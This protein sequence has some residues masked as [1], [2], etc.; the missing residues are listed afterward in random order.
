MD[1]RHALHEA[2]CSTP[3]GSLPQSVAGCC[4]SPA[5]AATA[6]TG[7][8]GATADSALENRDR[9]FDNLQANATLSHSPFYSDAKLCSMRLRMPHRF[10]ERFLWEFGRRHPHAALSQVE[11][12]A[13]RFAKM[14]DS[15]CGKVDSASCFTQQRHAIHMEIRHAYAEVQHICGSLHS[16]GEDAFTQREVTLLSQKAP[17]ASFEKVSQLARHFL[18]LAQKCC[19][20][21][22]AA[23]CFLEERYA[24]HDELCHDDEVV[25]QVA[26]LAAC[27]A[28][29]GAAR[30]KCLEQLPRTEQTGQ[31]EMP[32]F[33][34]Q[35]IC[36]L[37]SENPEMLMEKIL[38]EF[39]RRHPDSAVSEVKHF[40]Q[41]FS[42]SVTECCASDKTH[43]CFVEKR[44]ALEK[45]IKD[46]EAKGQATCLQ[47]KTEGINHFEQLVMVNYAKAA[48][49]LT[50]ESVFEFAHRFARI[51]HQCCEHDT[52]C[53]LD[54]S[55]HLHAEM[56]GD[57]SYITAHPGAATC[58]KS[59]VSEQGACFK[60]HEDIHRAEDLLTAP[61]VPE[62]P[63]AE[64]VCLRY[65]QFPE[66][67]VN[68]ALYEFAHRLPLLDSSVLRSKALAYAD[69]TDD[70]CRAVDKTACFTEKV[71]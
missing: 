70:C 34:E 51:A 27:C 63:S 29:S 45:V 20:P 35:K 37:R 57:H 7:A 26:G 69:F 10:L 67:F 33:D 59:D 16:R 32:H 36:E 2:I 12:L 52:H 15:C 1:H 60:N 31:R 17:N 14:A 54:E 43:D 55:L 8:T 39:G 24:I 49:S 68:L 62:Q 38:Y 65:R 9:C 4:N 64:R 40:A 53:L 56:C 28:L 41:K 23:G 30:A 5:T 58:C 13:E 6:A 18:S 22:H 42:H 21:D 71:H 47:L 46:E 3:S 50:M 61:A 66:K 44:A 25:E 11:E 48:Q 19:A